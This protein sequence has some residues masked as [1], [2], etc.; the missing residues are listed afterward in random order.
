[1]SA[2]DAGSDLARIARDAHRRGI[3]VDAETFAVLDLAK[4]LWQQSGGAFDVTI[5]P[6]LARDGLLPSAAAG[7]CA[8]AGRMDALH[9]DT[10]RRVRADVPLALDLGGIAKGHAVDCAVA[11]LRAEGV[12]EGRRQCRRRP[13]RV[14]RQRVDADSRA[15][16]CD[17]HEDAANVRSPRL[18]RGHVGR[19]FPRTPR[20]PG[21]PP[22]AVAARIAALSAQH[23]GGR[24]DLRA[25]GCT[26]EDRR[27]AARGVRCDPRPA[28][29]TR[30]HVRR[31]DG[32][33]A[34]R[35]D[36]RRIE[37]EPAA[38]AG[39]GSV[40]GNC[41]RSPPCVTTA[42]TIAC[43]HGIGARSTR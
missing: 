30:V 4:A 16:S 1:M 20:K 15:P 33:H 39:R 19:L 27:A 10:G 11:A 17:T 23:H 18:R 7:H 2:H 26:D 8:H 31:S 21:R 22:R 36:L 13:A 3:V 25:G 14:R 12:R 43:R 34:R 41:K 24:A 5:A 40:I 29:R 28:W 32:R 42:C 38:T 37:R 35:N 9:L 6:L